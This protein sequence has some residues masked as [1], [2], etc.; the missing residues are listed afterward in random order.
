M[1]KTGSL[2]IVLTATLLSATEDARA[3]GQAFFF[4][5]QVVAGTSWRDR[6]TR[7]QAYPLKLTDGDPGIN[8]DPK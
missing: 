1:R 5:G 7:E 4:L 3:E 2:I 6:Y 8:P